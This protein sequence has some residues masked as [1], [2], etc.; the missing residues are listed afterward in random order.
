MDQLEK[1]TR[2]LSVAANSKLRLQL[3]SK[4]KKEEEDSDHKFDSSQGKYLPICF[5]KSTF[6]QRFLRLKSKY[7]P[8]ALLS[9]VWI[10]IKLSTRLPPKSHRQSHLAL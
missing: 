7:V 2:G 3:V 9:Y 5:L 10:L 1:I 8:L 4:G 6:A